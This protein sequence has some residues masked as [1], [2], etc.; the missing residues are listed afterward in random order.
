MPCIWH[1]T[2]IFWPTEMSVRFRLERHKV[3]FFGQAPQVRPLA[4][5]PSVRQRQARSRRHP[6]RRVFLGSLCQGWDPTADFHRRDLQ[7]IAL[8]ALLTS[9]NVHIS[10]G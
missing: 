7:L 3:L 6:D 9:P 5:I 1:D 10:L 2:R 4:I 8:V